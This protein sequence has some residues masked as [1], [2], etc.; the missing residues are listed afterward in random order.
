MWEEM[1]E[2]NGQYQTPWDFPD[3][4]LKKLTM[5]LGVKDIISHFSHHFGRA[6][7]GQSKNHDI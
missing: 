5:F 1:G 3:D 6:M 7:I 4:I 2:R